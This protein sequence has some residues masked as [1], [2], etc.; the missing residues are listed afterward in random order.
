MDTKHKK[1]VSWI[2]GII[3]EATQA[4]DDSVFSSFFREPVTDEMR[5]IGYRRLADYISFAADVLEGK[6]VQ[7][8]EA[9]K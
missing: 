4:K 2:S 6:K 3:K 8:F 7:S 5:A 9:N 1:T